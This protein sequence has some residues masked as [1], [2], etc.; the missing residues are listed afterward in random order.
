MNEAEIFIDIEELAKFI[1]E[2]NIALQEF[3]DKINIEEFVKIYRNYISDWIYQ[4]AA[5]ATETALKLYLD[6]H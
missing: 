6:I 3:K 4:E 1:L 2:H 5:L